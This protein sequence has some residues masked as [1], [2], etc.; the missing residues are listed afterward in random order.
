MQVMAGPHELKVPDGQMLLAVVRCQRRPP[1]RDTWRTSVLCAVSTDE[2]AIRS[3]TG[4]YRWASTAPDASMPRDWG[5]EAD[6]MVD[7]A[8]LGDWLGVPGEYEWTDGHVTAATER[9]GALHAVIHPTVGFV[10]KASSPRRGPFG[11]TIAH[12]VLPRQDTLMQADDVD[13]E[14]LEALLPQLGQGV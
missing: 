5:E 8:H 13:P 6:A 9:I 12:R 4:K 11:E 1:A 2:V 10:V 14:E 7:A 3:R